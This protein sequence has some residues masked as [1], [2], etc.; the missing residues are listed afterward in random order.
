M[1]CRPQLD[2]EHFNCTAEPD[3]SNIPRDKQQYGQVVV[4]S[5]MFRAGVDALVKLIL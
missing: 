5:S 3:D 2:G 4:G 1:R